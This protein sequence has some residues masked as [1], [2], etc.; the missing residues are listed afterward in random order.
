MNMAV[1]LKE[2]TS[3][4]ELVT[5]TSAASRYI[6]VA[7]SPHFNVAARILG[8]GKVSVRVEFKDEAPQSEKNIV[9]AAGLSDNG[10]HASMHA[11]ANSIP[12]A[13][14]TIAA[15]LASIAAV[16]GFTEVISLRDISSLG[17][18]SV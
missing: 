5:G 15:V 14:A 2:A 1:A 7:L 6:T 11:S 9:L 13:C 12:E 10:S 8:N 4:N 3:L 17:L 18:H 16:I